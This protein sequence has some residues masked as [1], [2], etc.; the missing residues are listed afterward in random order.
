M[1]EY[2]TVD[3][4]GLWGVEWV[5]G[6]STAV[7][8][9]VGMHLAVEIKTHELLDLAWGQ[10]ATLYSELGFECLWITLNTIM[11]PSGKM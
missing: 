1:K 8:W 10:G 11:H 7:H 3:E 5:W 9:A 2:V 6:I 4:A